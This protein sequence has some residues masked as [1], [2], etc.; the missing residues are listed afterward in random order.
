MNWNG[1]DRNALGS[2]DHQ[3]VDLVGSLLA[4]VKPSDYRS[5]WKSPIGAVDILSN[6]AKDLVKLFVGEP[7]H[8]RMPV[9]FIGGPNLIRLRSELLGDV[10][11]I[12]IREFLAD[13]HEKG[14]KSK[15]N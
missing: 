8:I 9:D 11:I 7:K 6:G 4:H 15:T 12:P 13:A 10:I 3:P 1:R 2:L 5:E 14:P